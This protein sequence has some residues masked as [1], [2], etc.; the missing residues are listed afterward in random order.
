MLVSDVKGLRCTR[1]N[2]NKNAYEIKFSIVC[3]ECGAHVKEERNEYKF[4]YNFSTSNDGYIFYCV[5]STMF[6]HQCAV[7]VNH[8]FRFVLFLSKFMIPLFPKAISNKCCGNLKK[9]EIMLSSVFSS[10]FRMES[11]V[12]ISVIVRQYCV[13][14]CHRRSKMI[15]VKCI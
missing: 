2:T 10:P 8:G 6:S 7:V 15:H 12:I 13:D 1:E 5:L 9:R 14:C 4:P 3:G 11:L